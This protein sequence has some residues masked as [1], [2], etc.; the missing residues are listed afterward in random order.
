MRVRVCACFTNW[1]T[2][3]SLIA[4]IL[5]TTHRCCV[6]GSLLEVNPQLINHPE[7]LNVSVRMIFLSNLI[8]LRLDSTGVIK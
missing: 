4:Y 8:F 3:E 2:S 6:K 1:V 5:V 7:L